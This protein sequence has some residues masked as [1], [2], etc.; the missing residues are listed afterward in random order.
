MGEWFGILEGMIPPPED[1][2]PAWSVPGV[3]DSTRYPE[4]YLNLVRAYGPGLFDDFMNLFVPSSSNM[5]SSSVYNT[6][7]RIDELRQYRRLNG[8]F[9]SE[10]PDLDLSKLHV[11]GASEMGDTMYWAADEKGIPVDLVVVDRRWDG[12][13]VLYQMGVLE[14][15][16]RLLRGDESVSM[17]PGDVPAETHTFES[18]AP[19]QCPVGKEEWGRPKRDER[20]EFA[21]YPLYRRDPFVS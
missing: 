9:P 10:L 13:R 3:G 7:V 4:D 17:C 19:G 11:W 5:H 2:D 20:Y 6:T 8:A 1:V 15:L 18:F 14:Y 12:E 21:K 16:V